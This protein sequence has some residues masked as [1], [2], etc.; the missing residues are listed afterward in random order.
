MLEV[1]GASP[2]CISYPKPVS[3]PPTWTVL[4]SWFILN[5]M[6][7]NR[8]KTAGKNWLW[9]AFTIL[10]IKIM[11]RRVSD[12]LW[13]IWDRVRIFILFG[14][15][16]DLCWTFPVVW[17]C[18]D[19]S[20]WRPQSAHP[21]SERWVD[22]GWPTPGPGCRPGDWPRLKSPWPKSSGLTSSSRSAGK[23]FGGRTGVERPDSQCR[24]PAFSGI[25][26]LGGRLYRDGRRLTEHEIKKSAAYLFGH[27]KKYFYEWLLQQS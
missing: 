18:H 23:G 1:A 5:Y 13:I 2:D 9:K 3:G 12:K 6:T 20:G 11:S 16:P 25:P 7:F 14:L 27:S 26:M 17:R 15:Y 24:S 4:H 22:P 8:A 10:R 19:S 21:E